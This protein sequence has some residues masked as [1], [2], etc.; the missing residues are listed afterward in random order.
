[1]HTECPL[2]ASEILRTMPTDDEMEG[3]FRIASAKRGR[4]DG[5]PAEYGTGV[6][7]NE[8]HMSTE[9]RR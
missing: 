7:W 4:D 9:Y 3:C 5:A 1:M 6:D 2:P 8:F